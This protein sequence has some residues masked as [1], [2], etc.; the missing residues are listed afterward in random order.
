MLFARLM[1]SGPERNL[2]EARSNK[3][4]A[5]KTKKGGIPPDTL[6]V[7]SVCVS[8]SS[9]QTPVHIGSAH[10]ANRR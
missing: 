10:T 9:R 4:E 6:C 1:R 7:S 8:K 5:A 3:E 2:N